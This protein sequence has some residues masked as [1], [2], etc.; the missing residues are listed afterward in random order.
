MRIRTPLI[1]HVIVTNENF[2]IKKRRWTR[3]TDHVRYVK[4]V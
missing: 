3:C 4:R 2:P 1:K